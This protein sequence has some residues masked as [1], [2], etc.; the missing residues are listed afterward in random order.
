MLIAAQPEEGVL[1]PGAV[2]MVSRRQDRGEGRWDLDH[3]EYVPKCG[4]GQASP[5]VSAVTVPVL[6]T[7]MARERHRGF[8]SH[9]LR[10]VQRKWPLTST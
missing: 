2:R 5:Q 9:A 7:A 8:K 6:K 4:P 10:V 1:I 3:A